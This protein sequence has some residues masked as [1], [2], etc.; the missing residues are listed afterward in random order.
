M[1]TIP[2]TSMEDFGIA[3]NVVSKNIER[4]DKQY[5]AFIRS[6]SAMH[7]NAVNIK[8]RREIVQIDFAYIDLELFGNARG[9]GE[10]EFGVNSFEVAP[11]TTMTMNVLVA[12]QMYKQMEKIL[13]AH[14]AKMPTEEQN[15]YTSLMDSELQNLGDF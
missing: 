5:L 3:Y 14:I 1:S 15:K 2:Q 10:H 11:H 4:D 8:A 7:T 6:L 12:I 13:K 9:D